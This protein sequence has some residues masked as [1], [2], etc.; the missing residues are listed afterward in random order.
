MTERS[1]Y[2]FREKIVALS[3]IC[4]GMAMSLF[5]CVCWEWK[6]SPYSSPQTCLSRIR[7][8]REWALFSQRVDRVD[9]PRSRWLVNLVSP[10][11]EIGLWIQYFQADAQLTRIGTG[12]YSPK[13]KFTLISC[14]E[15]CSRISAVR[16]PPDGTNTHWWLPHQRSENTVAHST[17]DHKKSESRWSSRRIGGLIYLRI[18]VSDSYIDSVCPKPCLDTIELSG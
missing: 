10:S 12:S 4:G 13:K 16:D 7:L 14:R 17:V 9:C 2:I 15:F 6:R 3:P 11:G 8:R 5:S 1:G 18:Q